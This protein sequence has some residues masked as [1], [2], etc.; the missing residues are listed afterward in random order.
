[1]NA[2][3]NSKKSI[4]KL[5][6]FLCGNRRRASRLHTLPFQAATSVPRA[7][8]AGSKVHWPGFP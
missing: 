5:S 7:D 4:G 6:A 1:M 3:N 2:G 8:G